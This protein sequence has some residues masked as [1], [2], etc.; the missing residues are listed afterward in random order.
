MLH[1]Y[2]PCQRQRPKVFWHFQGVWKW[3]R[4]K[5]VKACC[6][7]T[8]CYLL[9]L[10]RFPEQQFSNACL[11]NYALA[12]L[13]QHFSIRRICLTYLTPMNPSNR[14]QLTD[15]YRFFHCTTL[16]KINIFHLHCHWNNWFLHHGNVN[17]TWVNPFHTTGLFL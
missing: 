12:C 13:C 10:R 17:L 5:L 14:N 1:L 15:L 6:F 2:T 4:L 11:G 8:S 7:I 3:N 16:P 9:I